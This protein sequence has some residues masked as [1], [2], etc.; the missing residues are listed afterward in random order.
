MSKIPEITAEDIIDAFAEAQYDADHSSKEFGD[1]SP[2]HCADVDVWSRGFGEVDG[3]VDF[4][5]V[6]SHLTEI[7]R[8]KA[9]EDVNGLVR[10]VTNGHQD[11][12]PFGLERAFRRIDGT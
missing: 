9:G 11:R 6:A 7:L 3:I 8:K 4:N 2:E 10:I 5:A 1:D 12:E